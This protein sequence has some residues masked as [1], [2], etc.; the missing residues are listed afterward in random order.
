MNKQEIIIKAV[1]NG[2]ERYI[3]ECRSKIPEFCEQTFSLSGAWEINKKAFGKDLLKAP[4][5]VVWTPF[6]FIGTGI[7]KGLEKLSMDK[8]SKLFAD[9]PAGFTTDVEL[10][11]QWRIYTQFIRLPYKQ[12]E[13]EFS[14]NRLLE[15]I[16]EDES[17]APIMAQSMESISELTSDEEGKNLLTE[18]I[19]EYTDSR[20]AAS[21]LS[22]TLIGTATGYLTSKTL[23]FGAVGLGQSIAASAA[24]HSAVSSFALGNTLGAAFYSV[25]PV[26]ASTGAIVISTGGVAAILGVVSAF[27]GVLADPIQHKLGLHEKKLHKLVDALEEQ[28]KSNEQSSLDIKDGY[29][30]RVLDVLDFLTMIVRK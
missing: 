17:L 30:A 1:E 10:E 18:R 13:R 2:I 7:G 27:A 25:V 29:A 4:A 21:E 16:L 22:S 14:D 26:S 23:N 15:I 6:Y 24:Y 19:F 8:A 9:L 28:F 5:N 11:V 20:K 12:E 3:R